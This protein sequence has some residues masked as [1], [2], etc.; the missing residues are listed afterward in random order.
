MI[1]EKN[2]NYNIVS[3]I[4]KNY[5]F[6]QMLNSKKRRMSY[7]N[8]YT[9]KINNS[10]TS[11]GTKREVESKCSKFN[12]NGKIELSKNILPNDIKNIYCEEGAGY[13]LNSKEIAMESIHLDD[14]IVVDFKTQNKINKPK[15][16]KKS[17]SPSPSSR[18]K[19]LSLFKGKI[20]KCQRKKS[21]QSP[22]LKNKF[23]FNES[24]K[25]LMM[26]NSKIQEISPV[27]D[28]VATFQ[29]KTKDDKFTSYCKQYY[30][31]LKNEKTIDKNTYKKINKLA[32]F[33]D[34][35]MR[36][37]ESSTKTHLLDIIAD[38]NGI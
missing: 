16:S 35:K 38:L 24:K 28:H 26:K 6:D 1:R 4:N 14:E 27:P 25:N 2:E 34:D 32:V 9:N 31:N 23:L 33:N 8:N 21:S 12:K 37:R 15:S 22:V 17:F 3:N 13:F 11:P 7:L 5:G 30:T 10:S 29:K 18:K 36:K 19:R 20:N